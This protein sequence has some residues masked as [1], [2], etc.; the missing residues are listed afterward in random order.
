[1]ANNDL[2]ISAFPLIE[3]GLQGGDIIPVVRY[4]ENM[5]VD[6]AYFEQIEHDVSEAQDTLGVMQDSD[7]RQNEQLT[8]LTQDMG[9]LN[10]QVAQLE[11]TTTALT[12]PTIIDIDELGPDDLILVIRDNKPVGFC[13]GEIQVDHGLLNYVALPKIERFETTITKTEKQLTHLTQ[14]VQSQAT[15]IAELEEQIQNPTMGDPISIIEAGDQIPLMRMGERK[16]IDGSYFVAIQNDNAQNANAIDALKDS[17]KRNGQYITHLTQDVSS[18]NT[19]VAELEDEVANLQGGGIGDPVESIEEGDKIPLVRNGQTLSLD[20]MTI[21]NL[22][23]VAFDTAT[24]V[25]EVKAEKQDAF[26]TSE[27]LQMA[28][29]VLSLTDA[30]KLR[31]FCDMFNVAVGSYGYARITDGVFD[32]ELNE[33]KLTY[34]DAM[35]SYQCGFPQAFHGN[36]WVLNHRLK[37]RTNIPFGPNY[38]SGLG[39]S[40]FYNCTAL[41]VVQL[42]GP[43]LI[44]EEYTFNY[45]TKLRSII[46]EITCNAGDIFRGCRNLVDVDVRFRRS[47]Y[48]GDSPL[49][50]YDSVNKMIEPSQSDITLTVHPDVYAKLTGDTTN[51]AAAALTPEEAAQWQSILT[52]AVEKNISFIEATA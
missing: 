38:S 2:P 40:I 25:D 51:D 21:A 41:E 42:I 13:G 11:E 52:N 46:G 29:N 6:G 49:L 5:A 39:G 47:S 50:S 18:L 12:N 17:D 15:Q 22:A 45:C 23:R 35:V 43:W 16:Y 3:D 36:G 34:E 9:G 37:L 28:D 33:L 44:S 26:T 27:D 19:Q 30:A 48:I 14:D 8:H 1:M 32:C 24:A 20:G 7:K 31:L 10:Q 4:G